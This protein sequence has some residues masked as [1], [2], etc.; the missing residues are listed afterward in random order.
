MKLIIFSNFK[1]NSKSYNK[2]STREYLLEIQ[3]VLQTDNGPLGVKMP[4]NSKCISQ[5]RNA[6]FQ[7]AIMNI[8]FFGKSQIY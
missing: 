5:T 4:T 7:N 2:N 3:F 8:I 6:H 1:K